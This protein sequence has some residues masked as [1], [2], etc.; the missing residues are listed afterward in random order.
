MS[1][2]TDLVAAL[3]ADPTVA[4]YVAS[5][6]PQVFRIYPMLAPQTAP[7]PYITYQVITGSAFNVTNGAPCGEQKRVQFNCVSNSY[8][9]AKGM[10]EAIKGALDTEYGYMVGEGDD[11]FPDTQNFRVRLDWSEIG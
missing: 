9:Q 1:I 11:Y 10:A 6:S 4:S 3:R 8:G 5:G 2:E 7:V